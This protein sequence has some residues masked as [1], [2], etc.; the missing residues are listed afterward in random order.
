MTE[1]TLKE[2]ISA[3]ENNNKELEQELSVIKNKPQGGIAYILL[4]IGLISL[5]ISVIHSNNIFAF[6]GVAI[7]FW[8]AILLYIKP[9][10]FTRI[11][12][13]TSTINPLYENIYNIINNLDYKGEPI[14]ISASSLGSYQKS[15]IYIPK[16]QASPIIEEEQLISNII[17]YDNPLSI[18]ISPPGL[19]LVKLIEREMGKNISSIN[20]EYIKENLSNSVVEKLEMAKSLQME[21]NNQEIQIIIKNNIFEENIIK[22]I[23]NKE[24]L[25]KI[26]DPLI[27]AIGCILTI[28]IKKPVQIKVYNYDKSNK[29]QEIKYNIL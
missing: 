26:G 11:E 5:A 22:N 27:S 17:F 29:I 23:E 16:Y 18:K 21:I 14:Y 4:S 20:I 10:K 25:K 1:E 28:T 6:I 8:G 24:I 3:L 15:Y 12:I 19:E 9:N 7:T 2:I 13:V